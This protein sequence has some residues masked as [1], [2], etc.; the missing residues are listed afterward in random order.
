MPDVSDVS[1]C[2]VRASGEDEASGTGENGSDDDDS[3]PVVMLLPEDPLDDIVE[4]PERA[5]LAYRDCMQSNVIY[6]I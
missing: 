4:H 5:P 2:E 6:F 3:E 1:D